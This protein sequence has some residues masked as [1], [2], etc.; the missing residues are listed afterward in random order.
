MICPFKE[1]IMTV[2]DLINNTECKR[3]IMIETERKVPDY[4]SMNSK[5]K[6]K[7]NKTE[8]LKMEI[9]VDD[10]LDDDE[11]RLLRK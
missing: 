1:E 8:I 11:F 10:K 3:Y 5:T 2:E 6:L 7:L 4:V 9:L